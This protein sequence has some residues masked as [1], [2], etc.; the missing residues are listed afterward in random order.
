HRTRELSVRIEATL[1]VLQHLY[2]LR[3]A[4]SELIQR[5]AIREVLDQNDRGWLVRL[6]HSQAHR[7]R[8][9]LYES[10][11]EE[12]TFATR[13]FHI[14]LPG[15]TIVPGRATV[16]HRSARRHHHPLSGAIT[17]QIGFA[18]EKV[19]PTIRSRFRWS[20]RRIDREGRGRGRFRPC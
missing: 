11:I 3:A 5:E 2:L 8:S 14:D 4:V 6:I 7:H 13:R 10:A 17:I 19:L 18:G 20:N 12:G 15:L 1:V 9:Q 16:D